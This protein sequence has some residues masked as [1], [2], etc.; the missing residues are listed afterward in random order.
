MQN[1]RCNKRSRHV[2][3]MVQLLNLKLDGCERGLFRNVATQLH[4]QMTI[5]V[6]A[7]F[8]V[9]WCGV[10]L[11]PLGKCR[12][13]VGLLY[14]SQMIVDEC[15][16]VGGMRIG[17]GNRNTRE[18]SAPLPLCLPRIPYDLTWAR[19]RTAWAMARPVIGLLYFLDVTWSI[20][21]S[22]IKSAYFWS[23]TCVVEHVRI[24]CRF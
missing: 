22:G 10:R 18:K 20:F 4:C 6:L 3:A 12:P 17:R 13:I 8:L 16:A 14:Q 5:I 9:S 7:F 15:G 2:Y 11:S 19:T 23:G 21:V 1:F 24:R